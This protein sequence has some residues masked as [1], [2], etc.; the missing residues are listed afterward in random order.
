MCVSTALGFLCGWM[1]RNIWIFLEIE[2]TARAKTGGIFAQAGGDRG[3]KKTR[4]RAKAIKMIKNDLL[5]FFRRPSTA[6]TAVTPSSAPVAVA[7]TPAAAKKREDPP[8][9]TAPPAAKV[10]KMDDPIDDADEEEDDEEEEEEE[11]AEEEEKPV[12]LSKEIELNSDVLRPDNIIAGRPKRK[13]SI[14]SK[15]RIEAAVNA[16]FNMSRAEFEERNAAERKKVVM[17][18]RRMADPSAPWAD[19]DNLG[20][21]VDYTKVVVCDP[22]Q[23][24][25][26]RMPDYALAFKESW[27]AIK[28]AV[29]SILNCQ[30]PKVKKLGPKGAMICCIVNGTDGAF[31]SEPAAV[32]RVGYCNYGT[33]LLVPS[34]SPVAVTLKYVTDTKFVDQKRFVVTKDSFR[35]VDGVNTFWH[36]PSILLNASISVLKALEPK[37]GADRA[38]ARTAAL[39]GTFAAT[40]AKYAIGRAEIAAL[41]AETYEDML[42]EDDAPPAVGLPQP[43]PPSPATPVAPAAA[44]ITITGA[45]PAA[46]PV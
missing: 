39:D 24:M 46:A 11:E 23:H 1:K 5:S 4:I 31:E 30:G 18:A 20:R 41:I 28:A 38:A 8:A 29:V 42:D 6:A 33:E 32:T 14:A 13:A 2:K 3:E 27:L 43:P 19:V 44:I 10:A 25:G 34:T 26:K 40:A 12:D 16:G 21:Y 17:L 45:A 37:P 36:L 15:R 35:R 7:V 9:G 22:K